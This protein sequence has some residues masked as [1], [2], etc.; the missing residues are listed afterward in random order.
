MYACDN[1]YIHFLMSIG[2]NSHTYHHKTQNLPMVYTAFMYTSDS[3]R[4]V[5]ELETC[6]FGIKIYWRRY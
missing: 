1:R 2:L 5:M 3:L 6:R 4:N